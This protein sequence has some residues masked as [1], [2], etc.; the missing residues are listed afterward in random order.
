MPELKLYFVFCY[1]YGTSI[2]QRKDLRQT[3]ENW[4]KF[5]AKIKKLLMHMHVGEWDQAIRIAASLP[6]LGKERDVIKNAHGAIINPDFYKQ[7]G[8]NIDEMIQNGIDGIKRKYSNYV[9]LEA[10]AS[11]KRAKT[12]QM[13]AETSENTKKDAIKLMVKTEIN[14]IQ[15]KSLKTMTG[16]AEFEYFGSVLIGT[17]IHFGTY[18]RNKK[19]VSKEQYQELL[20]YFRGKTVPI[21]TSHDN[22]PKGSLGEWL[23]NNVSKTQITSYVVQIIIDE[24]Y[25]TKDLDRPGFVKFNAS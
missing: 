16:K 11:A 5:E 22:P 4:M 8:K 1:L 20:H 15:R 2:L 9:E 24:G 23:I 19:V 7:I 13:W 10:D 14:N 6:D 12:A 18:L 17:D 21:G 25:A 3:C